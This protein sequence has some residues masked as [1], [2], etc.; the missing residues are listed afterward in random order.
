V[1][2]RKRSKT[3]KAQIE[4]QVF[5]YIM[6][7]VIGAGILIYGYNAIKGFRSQ[8]DE[9][10]TLQFEATIKNDLKS[11]TYESTKI[12]TFDLP[13]LV[14]DVCFKTKGECVPGQS[15]GVCPIDVSNE[16]IRNKKN[17]DLIEI[18]V[19]NNVAE[20]VFLY[21]K[22]DISFFSGVNINLGNSKFTC[23]EVQNGILRLRITGKG[24]SVLV[25]SP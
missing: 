21:P 14:T 7:L 15:G 12:K 23:F 10:L 13:G 8:A 17:Y 3:N 20:N 19:G 11:L 6:V 18:S 1:K 9:V 5:V 24:D 4:T 25:E 16:G 2:F 22:G